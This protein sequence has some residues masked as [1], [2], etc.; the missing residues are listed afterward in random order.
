MK[1]VFVVALMAVVCLAALAFAG[2]STSKPWFDLEKCAFCKTLNAEPGLLEHM[3]HDYHNIESGL[4][5]VT[6]IDKEFQ[7]AFERA[8]GNMMKVVADLQAGKD[9]YFCEHCTQM[10][11]FHN[12]NVKFED[13][14]T[15]FG[16]VMLW[17]SAEPEVIAKLQAF[18]V[19]NTEEMAK[20]EAKMKQS[21][22][23]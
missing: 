17:T 8:H 20:F 6:N 1:K 3:K 16:S 5:C 10:G 23:H 12:M 14:K 19:R 11:E 9:V 2:D 7:P 18:G 15:G 4:L 22:K 13:V 21:M